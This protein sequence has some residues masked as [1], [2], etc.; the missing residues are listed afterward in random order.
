MVSLLLF[1]SIILLVYLSVYGL[2]FIILGLTAFWLGTFRKKTTK[3]DATRASTEPV[4]VLIPSYNEGGGLLD[5]V[6]AVSEQD[7]AG[8]VEIY[9]LLN[10]DSDNSIGQLLKFYKLEERAPELSNSRRLTLLRDSDRR[11][12]LVLTNK[13]TKRDKFNFILPS[14][15][16]SFVAFLDADHRPA[17]NWLSTSA[18]LF[19]AENIAAVQ[20]RRRPLGVSHLAQIWDSSQNHFGNELLNYALT[21]AERSVF[22]TGTAAVFRTEILRRFNLSDSVTEDTYLSYDLWCAGYKIIYNG[23]TSSFEEVAPSFSD[24]VARR[25]R[26]SAGHNQAFFEH[27]GL[28]IRAKISWSDTFILLLHGQFYLIPLAVWLLL[29]VYG[30]YFFGQ[31]GFNFQLGVTLSAIFSGFV[32]A[33]AFRQ[34]GRRIWGD[35]LVGGLWLWPQFAAWSVYIYKFM[36][37]ENYYYILIFPYAKEWLFWQIALLSAPLVALILSLYFFRD[38][39]PGKNIWAIPTYIFTLFL[40]IYAVLLGLMDFAFGRARWSRIGRRNTYSTEIIPTDLSARLVTGQPLPKQRK[41]WFILAVLSLIFFVVLNDLLA[42]NNC[43]EIKYFLW[44]PLFL[45]TRSDVNF[46]VDLT[47][48][49]APA[50]SASP[51]EELTVKATAQLSGG[52]GDFFVHYYIDQK[53]V[54]TQD[55]RNGTLTLFTVNYPLGWDKHNLTV[56]LRG[57]GGDWLMSCTRV[58]PFST[59]LKELRGTDLYVNNEK[60]LVKGIIPSFANGQIALTMAEGFRQFKEIGINTVRFYH[61][62]NEKLL[63]EAAA[64]GLLIIDQPDRSTWNE[65]NLNSQF[66]TS[67][68]FGRYRYLVREHQGEPFVLWDGFG[69]EWELG[70]KLGQ[71]ASVD[72]TNRTILAALNTV[73]NWPTTYSTYI[74]FIKYPVDI[75]GINML[76]TGE[77]YWQNA[78]SIIK[79]T[80]K[81][82]YASEFGGFVAF[83]EKT[84]PEIRI[85]RLKKEWQILLENGTL[86][87]NFYESHDNWAQPVVAGYNDPFKSDQPDDARGFWD[88]ENK[89]KPELKVLEEILSDLRVTAVEKVIDDTSRPVN[90]VFQNIRDY[91]LKQV[92][93]S[94]PGG[95]R[96]LGDFPALA[97]S[98]VAIDFGPAALSSSPLVLKFSY[99]SHSGLAGYARVNLLLPV[100][101]EKPL[102]LNGDFIVTTAGQDFLRGRLISSDRLSVVLPETWRNFSLN[103]QNY[104]QSSAR[105]DFPLVNPYHAVDK[106]EFSRDGRTWQAVD[107]SFDPGPGDYYFRFRWPQLNAARELLILSG[108]GAERVEF[109]KDDKTKTINT[110]SYRE[111]IVNPLELANPRP[112]DLLTFKIYRDQTVYVDKNRVEKEYKVDFNLRGDI[113]VKFEPPRI[114]APLNIELKKIP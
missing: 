5:A 19:T 42:V 20:A 88:A 57:R 114:F 90:L 64:Q 94:W 101:R 60:F 98:T 9:I 53:L 48:S 83:W 96:E 99:F 27:L 112:G 25:R 58:L 44:R 43:G 79:G 105:M 102:V 41:R 81:P 13:Q 46:K 74:T 45:K 40:D 16:T 75:S 62:A 93:V 111:N 108:L 70:S 59:T 63:Q 10:D 49:L 2:I 100:K 1:I 113:S 37:S 34:T 52:Q 14:V 97:S 18:A 54:G 26:W 33:Y 85:N 77:T 68:Y 78:L 39:R 28:I 50:E 29:S 55:M 67:L 47:K 3:P 31:I 36:G 107:D 72:L 82:F 109:V 89:P 103:G 76:D 66:Q 17:K 92:V 106:L 32:L 61:R 6:I 56:N 104:E 24:Y 23:A 95:S 22:F 80:G 84:D 91:S 35:W 8:S 15:T 69:N 4:S 73:S 38:S 21:A 86:G 51:S 12:D 30:L 7:Y 71:A 11:V 110:H 65:F 87:A